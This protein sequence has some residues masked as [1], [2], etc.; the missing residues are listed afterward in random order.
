MTKPLKTD[1]LTS[2]LHETEAFV[3]LL[4]HRKIPANYV[5][6]NI[7]HTEDVVKNALEITRESG[8]GKQSRAIVLIAAWF[9]DTGFVKSYRDHERYSMEIAADFLSNKAA[10]DFIREVQ[11]C[12]DATRT[13]QNPTTYEAQLVCDAD[14]LHLGREDFLEKSLR[15]REEWLDVLGQEHPYFDFVKSSLAFLIQHHFFSEY[16]I[17]KYKNG[18]AHNMQKLE[19]IIS[20]R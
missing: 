20:G 19:L 4:L 6:H 3:R 8:C 1:P 14:M 18:K 11:L 7:A 10:P 16:A 17:E 15:L 13:P 9:H 2:L 12:I 5:Y